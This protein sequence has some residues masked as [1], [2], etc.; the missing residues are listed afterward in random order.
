MKKEDKVITFLGL[1]IVIGYGYAMDMPQAL[2]TPLRGEPCNLSSI[3]INL[4]YFCTYF[5][6]MFTDIPLGI[7]LDR[8]PLRK[9]VLVIAFTSFF[10]SLGTAILFDLRPSVYIYMVYVLKA[11]GGVAGSCAFTVQGMVI[12][13][14]AAEYFEMMMGFGIS[15]PFCF[16]ALNVTI[17]PY[18]YDSTHSISLP[19]YVATCV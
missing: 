8:F 19:W 13:R 2:E 12:A 3:E 14:F 18:I 6:V 17:T 10:A 1:V 4:L 7:L 16:D 15:L 11:L 5:P 9:S